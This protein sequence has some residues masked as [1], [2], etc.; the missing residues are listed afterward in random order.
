MSA[1]ASSD[2][3]SFATTTPPSSPRAVDGAGLPAEAAD[4]YPML[5][6]NSLTKGEDPEAQQ[7]C[8][9]LQAQIDALR[10]EVLLQFMRQEKTDSEVA[11]LRRA[12]DSGLSSRRSES[13]EL[14]AARDMCSSLREELMESMTEVQSVKAA[15]DEALEASEAEVKK[16]KQ[17]LVALR[18][19][20]SC[21]ISRTA[22]RE[23]VVAADGHTY[24]RHA[25]EAWIRQDSPAQR[26]PM[27]NE[28]LE[29]PRLVAN[30]FAKQVVDCLRECGGEFAP[31]ASPIAKTQSSEGHDNA[32]D[33]RA[34]LEAA[35]SA[36]KEACL[37]L[38][39]SK[40]TV[41]SAAMGP[42]DLSRVGWI[43]APGAAPSSGELVSAYLGSGTTALH[44]AAVRGWTDVCDPL[45]KTSSG[46][47]AAQR[48]VGGRLRGGPFGDGQF[49][50]V[51]ARK[52]AEWSGNAATVAVFSNA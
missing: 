12:V 21:P 28:P 14:E 15:F 40:L 37:R 45:L 49:Y 10:Q 9:G 43:P 16:L 51:D 13:Q 8:K 4:G 24:E 50:D 36:D 48:P 42:A 35:I 32:E 20:C 30:V 19:Q 39:Q 23:P 31:E 26:S 41:P 17:K 27:T 2:S 47:E 11:R 46:L 44:L 25:I 6:G 18:D 34:L 3:A 38:V 5:L 1:A 22:L 7:M 33:P 52:L 29:S